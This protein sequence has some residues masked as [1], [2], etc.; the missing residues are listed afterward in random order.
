MFELKM[1]KLYII[2][3]ILILLVTLGYDYLDKSKEVDE[4]KIKV[5][6]LQQS[7]LKEQENLLKCRDSWYNKN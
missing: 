3:I 2:A 5:K 6:N 4:L 7:I 1:F